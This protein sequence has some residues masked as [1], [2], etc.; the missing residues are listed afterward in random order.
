MA[1]I[2]GVV[3]V[4]WVQLARD[5]GTN[6]VSLVHQDDLHVDSHELKCVE[7][8]LNRLAADDHPVESLEPAFRQALARAAGGPGRRRV[9]Y[10]TLI[11]TPSSES[12]DGRERSL[13]WE[14][15]NWK[16]ALDPGPITPS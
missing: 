9:D 12:L 3:I 6:A 14:I 4:Y 2:S 10:E 7:Y 1:V 16:L 15:L 11:G 5:A 8:E 13:R